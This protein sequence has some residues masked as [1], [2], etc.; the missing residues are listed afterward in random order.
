MAGYY[1][2]VTLHHLMD[3]IDLE[4]S[5][6]RFPRLYRMAGTIATK[7]LVAVE[8]S[9]GADAGISKYF[10]EQIRRRKR[11]LPHPWHSGQE[12]RIS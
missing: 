11:S 5:G 7:M 2:H 9:F 3:F 4:G 6:I 12:S 8:F 10:A 1:T